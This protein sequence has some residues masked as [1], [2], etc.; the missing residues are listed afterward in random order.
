M[1][2]GDVVDITFYCGRRTGW[3]KA[4]C[5]AIRVALRLVGLPRNA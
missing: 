5:Q 1:I 2:V 4:A 3:P